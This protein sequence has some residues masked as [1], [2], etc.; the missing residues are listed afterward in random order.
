M[1]G[2]SNGVTRQVSYTFSVLPPS[3]PASPPVINTMPAIPNLADWQSHMTTYGQQ[4]CNY[5][6]TPGL[7]FDQRFSWIYYDQIRVMYQISDYIPASSSTW[8][9]CA[10]KA[11]GVCRDEYVIPNNGGGARIL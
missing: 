7:T 9:A 5:L 6:D 4:V 10:I 8:N 3:A 11:R 1:T 2:V